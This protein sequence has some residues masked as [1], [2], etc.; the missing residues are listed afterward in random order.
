MKLTK[1]ALSRYILCA[2]ISMG[3]VAAQ[4]GGPW[5]GTWKLNLEKSKY[6][7]GPGPAPGGTTIFKMFPMGDGFKYTIDTTSAQG[8]TSHSEAFARFDNKDYPETG[9]PGADTNRFRRID[10]HTYVLT[11]RKTGKDALSFTIIISAD[12][13]TRTSVATGKTPAGQEVH[14]IGVWDRQ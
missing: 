6:S 13:K 8:K 10:D 11:D 12:G 5:M 4:S 7:P 14:N 3:T 1:I 9:N 2:L